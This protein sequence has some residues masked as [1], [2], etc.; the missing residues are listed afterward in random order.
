MGIRVRTPHV[1]HLY[2]IKYVV[3][4]V[5]MQP[6]SGRGLCGAHEVMI[7]CCVVVPMCFMFVNLTPRVNV[8]RLTDVNLM[9]F[10]GL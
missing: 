9:F 7:L 1:L 10:G 3:R 5:R 8:P 2:A 6:L 4:A